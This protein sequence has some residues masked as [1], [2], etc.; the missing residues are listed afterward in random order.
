MYPER[1]VCQEEFPYWTVMLSEPVAHVP[2]T[3]YEAV[4]VAV[5]ADTNEAV[6]A[7]KV[8]IEVSLELHVVELVTSVPLRAA[9]NDCCVPLEKVPLGG[10]IVRVCELPPVVLPVIV[11]CTPA[12][13]AVIVTLEL[14]PT[15]VTTPV[16][17]TV[18]HEVELDQLTELVTIFVPLLYVAVAVNC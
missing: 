2:V 11:P 8:R 9:V 17:L 13:V 3:A 1:R 16:V 14:G 4:I 15:A 12:S 10:F 5:P 6:L 7:V 18:A